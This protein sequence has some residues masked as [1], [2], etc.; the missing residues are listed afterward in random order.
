M[1]EVDG[2]TVFLVGDTEAE[3]EWVFVDRVLEELPIVVAI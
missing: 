1:V 3:I 2:G